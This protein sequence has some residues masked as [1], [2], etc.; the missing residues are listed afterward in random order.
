VAVV[1]AEQP[2]E[3]RRGL[4]A[5]LSRVPEAVPT[6]GLRSMTDARAVAD[7]AARVVLVRADVHPEPDEAA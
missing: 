1:G 4:V 6:V 2:A 7:A 3:A 5:Y